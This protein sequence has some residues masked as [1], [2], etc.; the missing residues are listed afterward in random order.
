MFAGLD[1][2][3]MHSVYIVNFD[4]FPQGPMNVP[5]NPLQPGAGFFRGWGL[6]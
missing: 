5:P 6:S 3:S 1:F 4:S 2:V